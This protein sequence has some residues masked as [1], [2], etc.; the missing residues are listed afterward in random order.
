MKLLCFTEYVLRIPII[1]GFDRKHRRKMPGEH[2]DHNDESDKE[3]QPEE[4]D[5]SAEDTWT[6]SITESDAEE[7]DFN[8]CRINKLQNLE[9]LTQIQVSS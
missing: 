1:F 6:I 4:E 8:Q 5:H 9:C 7:L 3:E 2:N